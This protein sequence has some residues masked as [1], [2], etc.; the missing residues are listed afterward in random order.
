MDGLGWLLAA[1]LLIAAGIAAAKLLGRKVAS[2]QDEGD[3]APGFPYEKRAPL[4]TPAERSFYGV[5]RS[6]AETRGWEVFA[7]VRLEDLIEVKKGTEKY[8]SHRNRIKARHVDF[9]VCD[10]QTVSPIV[11]IELQDSSHARTDRQQRDAFVS[12]ALEAAGLP[13][14]AISPQRAYAV[15]ELSE[16]IQGK[17]RGEDGAGAVVEETAVVETSQPG[18]GG[19]SCPKCGSALVERRSKRTGE[20]FLGCSKY[21][22]CRHTQPA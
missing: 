15:A 2:Q 12:G 5:L 14:L 4:L 11:A 20:G 19:L 13:L 21:P 18:A 9:L 6:L 10:Q 1:V 22:A 16:M 7:K 3:M 17:L 8:Q